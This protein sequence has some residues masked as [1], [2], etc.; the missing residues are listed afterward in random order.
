M[1]GAVGK[2]VIGHQ[3]KNSASCRRIQTRNILTSVQDRKRKNLTILTKLPTY[4]FGKCTKKTLPSSNIFIFQSKVRT[5]VHSTYVILWNSVAKYKLSFYYY[6]ILLLLL[7]PNK[8]TVEFHLK[9]CCL[10]VYRSA[11]TTTLSNLNC[12]SISTSTL[13]LP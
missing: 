3:Y 8:A 7:H 1:R 11:R 9:K 6:I 5:C 2:Q 4:L 13:R 12:L 10:Q